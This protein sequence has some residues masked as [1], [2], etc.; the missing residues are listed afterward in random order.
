M[1]GRGCGP[2]CRHAQGSQ[3]ELVNRAFTLQTAL[4][5]TWPDTELPTPAD[6]D[7]GGIYVP[8]VLVHR[9]SDGR[10]IKPFRIAMVYAAPLA[11]PTTCSIWPTP[12]T[13]RYLKSMRA[14][15]RNV[16]RKCSLEEH[17][18]IVLGAWGCDGRRLVEKTQIADMFHEALLG[19]NDADPVAHSF[20]RV[21]FAIPKTSPPEESV[22]EIFQNRFRDFQ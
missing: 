7:N 14:K 6:E 10:R 3:Q 15:I 9:R 19:S 18:E 8:Q 2:L 12:E 22:F 4:V 20:S 1:C 17:N 21:T 11:P 13:T 16:L 5:A